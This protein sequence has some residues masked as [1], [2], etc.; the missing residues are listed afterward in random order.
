MSKSWTKRQKREYARIRRR[1]NARYRTSQNACRNNR[2]K[3]H[4]SKI[5]KLVSLFRINGC[6]LCHEQDDVCLC[7]H[8]VDPSQKSFE[9]SL[10]SSFPVE[11]VVDE[12]AKCVCLCLNCHAKVH[13]GRFSDLPPP[14]RII[15][16]DPD[17]PLLF[18]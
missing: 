5:K 9:I 4:A 13:A 8:H 7:A 12:L 17:Q 16:D 6:A 1:N 3:D 18:A 2:R 14:V 11:M 15:M 10:A